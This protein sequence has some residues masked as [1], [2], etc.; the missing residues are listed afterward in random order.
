MTEQNMSEARR[1]LLCKKPK[2]SLQGC[3]VH[4][5]V[6][7]CMAL[8]RE[9]REDEAAALLWENNPLSAVTSLVCDWKQFCFGNCVLN[10]K[11]APVH[12]YKVEQEIS[13]RY[14]RTVTLSRSGNRLV[15]KKVAV[16]G[17]GPAGIAASVW[18]YGEG[19][20]IVLYDANPEMG[21]VLRYGIPPFRM[22][23]DLVAQYSRILDVPGIEFRGGS[24][25]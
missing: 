19:A 14:L 21:G 12:W 13:G 2:C 22:D 17:A 4:T 24:K 25:V 20:D 10:V 1:C 18:L 16:V 3:P 6:P 5:P 23:R 11:Q 9:G 15:G 7:E 8:Y